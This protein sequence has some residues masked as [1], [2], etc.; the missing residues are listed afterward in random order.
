MLTNM[1]LEFC[2]YLDNEKWLVPI[3]FERP[4]SL[5]K[6]SGPEISS[7]YSVTMVLAETVFAWSEI[8]F[9]LPS[10][11]DPCIK[12]F[13]DLLITTELAGDQR[14][15]G[16]QFS[17]G[18]QKNQFLKKQGAFELAGVSIV[19]DAPLFLSLEELTIFH[20]KLLQKN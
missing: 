7:P 10:N 15:V 2:C 6:D 20:Q 9:N 19:I 13:N 18:S 8:S 14:Q 5:H 12:P 17:S 1:I 4:L 16:R 3:A 11:S